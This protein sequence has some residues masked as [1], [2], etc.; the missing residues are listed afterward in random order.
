MYYVTDY[1]ILYVNT[2]EFDGIDLKWSYFR[3]RSDVKVGY[4]PMPFLYVK[5]KKVASTLT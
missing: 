1:V 4:M 5:I 3:L 2:A